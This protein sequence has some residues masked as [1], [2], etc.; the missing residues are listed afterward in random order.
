VRRHL[1]HL[2]AAAVVLEQET[3]LHYPLHCL[4]LQKMEMLDRVARA[5]HLLHQLVL[6]LTDR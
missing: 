4:E 3:L 1:L 2:V 5:V 6:V